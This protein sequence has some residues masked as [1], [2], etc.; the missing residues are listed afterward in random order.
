V[1]TFPASLTAHVAAIY[2]GAGCTL[3]SCL[4]FGVHLM[5][6]QSDPPYNQIHATQVP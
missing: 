4:N 1:L 5:H 3:A 6:R 2:Y